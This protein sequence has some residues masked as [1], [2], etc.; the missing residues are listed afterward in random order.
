MISQPPVLVAQI[1]DTHLFADP[2]EGKMYG[3]PTE[4]SFLKVLEKLKQL[5]PQPDVLLLT[6]DLSQDETSESY[7]RLASLPK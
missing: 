4:S 2:T 6:G 3:L 7:Q 5:Q 1:T